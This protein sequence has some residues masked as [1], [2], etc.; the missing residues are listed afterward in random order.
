MLPENVVSKNTLNT[1][2]KKY[3]QAQHKRGLV[4]Q[5]THCCVT[6]LFSSHQYNCNSDEETIHYIRLALEYGLAIYLGAR[7]SALINAG[8]VQDT[9]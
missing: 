9:R 6:R 8:S 4:S 7:G 2:K 5:R 3:L 1:K